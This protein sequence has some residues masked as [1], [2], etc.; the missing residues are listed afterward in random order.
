[1]IEKVP[2]NELSATLTKITE[3]IAD[4]QTWDWEGVIALSSIACA[5]YAS[6]VIQFRN[7]MGGDDWL[8]KLARS[9]FQAG[10]NSLSAIEKS[11][12]N[13]ATVKRVH[14]LSWSDYQ[15]LK[16][17]TANGEFFGQLDEI[18]GDLWGEPGPLGE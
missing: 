14:D 4:R 8:K 11:G 18:L 17:A 15:K 2:G 13:P 9:A 6:I 12:A 10:A 3:L 7:A 5:I 16:N 1:V